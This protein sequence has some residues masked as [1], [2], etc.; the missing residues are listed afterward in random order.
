MSKIHFNNTAEIEK[1]IEAMA[2][3]WPSSVVARKAIKDFSGG[4][5]SPKTM[6]NEDCNGTGPEGR[7]LLMNQTVYPIKSLVTWLKSR[8]ATSWA[9]RKAV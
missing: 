1:I 4:I 9:E 5:L 3:E 8:S 6:A 2:T 7:F